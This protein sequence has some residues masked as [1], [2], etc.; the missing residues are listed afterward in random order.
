MLLKCIFPQFHLVLFGFF[1]H[2]HKGNLSSIVI[3]FFLAQKSYWLMCYH[4]FY[5][6]G[7]LCS[8]SEQ[9]YHTFN[10]I[11]ESEYLKKLSPDRK[12]D[13]LRTLTACDIDCPYFIPESLWKTD[14]T[15]YEKYLPQISEHDY[16]YCYCYNN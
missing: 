14:P 10:L 13:Y 3:Q 12:K 7:I 1:L 2:Q 6:F 16:C 8:M 9:V 11:E 4:Y 15:E 5:P